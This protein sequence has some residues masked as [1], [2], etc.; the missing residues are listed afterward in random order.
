MVKTEAIWGV[1]INSKKHKENIKKS[2][3]QAPD[4]PT[5]PSTEKVIQPQEVKKTKS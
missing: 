4:P 3:V 2:I 1:H 5:F